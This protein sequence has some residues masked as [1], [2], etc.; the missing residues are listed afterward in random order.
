MRISFPVGAEVTGND[1]DHVNMVG[2]LCGPEKKDSRAC[3]NFRGA[4]CFQG[5][6]DTR[7][8]DFKC[9]GMKAEKN[10]DEKRNRGSQL[11]RVGRSYG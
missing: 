1:S 8:C 11:K 4:S 6:E 10:D 5:P 3:I 7:S 9:W 2:G